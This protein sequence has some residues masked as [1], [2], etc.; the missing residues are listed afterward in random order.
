VTRADLHRLVDA[1]PEESLEPAAVVLER[2]K[3]P[4]LARLEARAS[5]ST[6]S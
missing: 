5:L 4:V 3:D 2:A 6:T 1:L